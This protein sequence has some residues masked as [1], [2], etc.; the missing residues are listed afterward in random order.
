[1]ESAWSCLWP[2][3]KGYQIP[4][5]GEGLLR[6]WGVSGIQ[7]LDSCSQVCHRPN[8]QLWI[9]PLLILLIV[10]MCS[11]LSPNKPLKEDCGLWRRQ[12]QKAKNPIGA[13]SQRL[14]PWSVFLLPLLWA[15]WLSDLL[16]TSRVFWAGKLRCSLALIVHVKICPGCCRPS[17]EKWASWDIRPF[18]T[19]PTL[20]DPA[21]YPWMSRS[22]AL[23]ARVT[24]WHLG[25]VFIYATYI[26]RE[27][28]LKS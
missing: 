17:E 5:G 22:F 16:P 8:S 6:I 3:D 11:S 2:G 18:G 13:C 14:S 1:M 23:Q 21:H 7:A 19:G 28:H 4:H 9:W 27:I 26:F 20:H 15:F 12:K 25:L 24:L 10:R